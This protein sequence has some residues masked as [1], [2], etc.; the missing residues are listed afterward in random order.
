MR[1]AVLHTFTHTVSVQG[2]RKKERGKKERKKKKKG[3]YAH[4]KH[5]DG[6]KTGG[7]HK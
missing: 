3:T 1:G 2:K 6:D 5:D 7:V 4:F